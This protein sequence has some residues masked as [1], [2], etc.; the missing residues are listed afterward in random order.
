MGDAL[1][2]LQVREVEHGDEI[3]WL[4]ARRTAILARMAFRLA[5]SASAADIEPWPLRGKQLS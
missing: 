4:I 3:R 2:R 5:C 1:L